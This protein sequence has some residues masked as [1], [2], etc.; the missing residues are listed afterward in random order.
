MHIN[1]L[2]DEFSFFSAAGPSPLF[3]MAS[4][5][6]LGSDGSA[7]S[8]ATSAE[9][10]AQDHADVVL[11]ETWWWAV[12]LSLSAIALVANLIFLITVIYNR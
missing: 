2:T 7:S 9:D 6:A 12:H 1:T 10:F 4:G 8:E 11:A 5:T 3:G